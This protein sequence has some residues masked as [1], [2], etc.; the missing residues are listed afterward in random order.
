[1][2][3]SDH[4]TF[5]AS[6]VSALARMFSP[7]VIRS[8][9]GRGRSP[10]FARLATQADLRIRLSAQAT[11]RDA[12]EAAFHV[13]AQRSNRHEYIY[14]SALTE[15]VLLG[16]H[17]LNTARMITEFRVGDCKADV[18]ILNGTSTAYE[19]KSERDSICRLPH[20]L[21]TY[22]RVFDHVHV[23]TGTNHLSSVMATA[24]SSVGVMVL[25]NRFQISTVR[26]AA[27]NRRNLDPTTLFESLQRQ[28]AKH[29]LAACGIEVPDVPNT[30]IHGVLRAA[31]ARIPADRLHDT[32][33]ATL[34]KHRRHLG[35]DEFI[36]CVPMSLRAA[37]ISMSMRPKERERFGAALSV[38]LHEALTW[39]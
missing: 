12:Y 7:G 22:L 29:M 30:E 23:I 34:K 8:F 39:S 11:V 33:V 19:I 32:F 3:P 20:Q 21:K 37:V 31:F 10:L 6:Q 38:Q 28:E 2:T 24:P 36:E 13:L 5:D 14:K 16:R 35:L 17:S 26:E 27:S 9:A 1:M 25:S 15:R 18:V 4:Q